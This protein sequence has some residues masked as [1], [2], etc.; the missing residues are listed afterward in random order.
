MGINNVMINKEDQSKCKEELYNYA[1]KFNFP[2]LA[3]TEGEKRAV[4]LTS[5]TFE[6]IGFQNGQVVKEQFNFSSFYSADVVKIFAFISLVFVILI[7]FFRYIFPFFVAIVLGIMAV[8]AISILRT[9]K[10]PE[11]ETKR[12]WGFRVGRIYQ[13]TNVYAKVPA[14]K[15]PEYQAPNIIVSAHL[16]TKSQSYRTIWRV[17]LFNIWLYGEILLGIFYGFFVIDYYELI[18]ILTEVNILYFEIGLWISTTLVGLANFF[19][20]GL[21]VK[22]ESPGAL[23][24]ASGMAIVF[25]LSSFFKDRALSHFNLWFCQFSGEER[26]TMGSR[27][28]VDNREQLFKKGKTFQFNFDMVS[29]AGH[30]K[31]RIEYLKSYGIYPRKKIAPLLINY[32]QIA[33]KMENLKIH[34]YHVSVGGHTDSIPF[35]LRKFDCVDIVTLAAAKYTH[36][37]EDD[38][39]KID[40]QI[41]METCYIVKKTL[42]LM[43][44]NY[45][46]SFKVI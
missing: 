27:I 39:D 43:D 36:S 33:A 23:D 30:K 16:D 19:I 7:L 1:K 5:K 6:E 34:G 8:I 2:R 45:E 42:Q 38:I 13:A 29:L 26:G 10:Y 20:L 40:P 32:M 44:E 11:K 9:L 3:G 28:F 21:K 14:K 17:I 4:S 15:I 18:K 12:F 24:N 41:L 35:H 22:N 25:E 46:K 37:V 31:N